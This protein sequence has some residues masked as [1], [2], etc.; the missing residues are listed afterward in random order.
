MEK[1][2]MEEHKSKKLN[3][4]V[5]DVSVVLS[6]IVA[7]F[8]VFSIAT[9]GIVSNQNGS[10]SY[11]APTGDSFT[12]VL[13]TYT[14]GDGDEFDVNV[15][16]T[17]G[18]YFYNFPMYYADSIALENQ[19][20]CV[21]RGLN[22]VGD[23]TYTKTGDKI[24]DPGLIYLLSLSSENGGNVTSYDD[25]ID[26]WVIQSA[27]WLYL[28]EKE[29]SNASYAFRKVEDEFNHIDDYKVLTTEGNIDIKVGNGSYTSYNVTG[30][31]RELV[32]AAKTATLPRVSV[33]K[34]SE[35][36]S[37]TT[38][39]QYYQTALITVAGSP[40]SSFTGYDISLTGIDGAIA[41]DENG[42]ELA[43]LT[44]VAPG[45]KFYVRVPVNKVTENVQTENVEIKGHFSA[46]SGYYYASSE[47]PQKM[48]T[49]APGD[50]LGGTSFELVYIPNTGMNTAQTIYF[51]GLIV[52]LCGIGIVYANAKPVESKQ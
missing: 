50:V 36:I 43:S 9:F 47:S 13:P 49:L 45:T 33:T 5:V 19:I 41:V 51:I 46:A 12:L 2:Y 28:Y 40:S 21:E 30:K 22:V 31:V 15:Q 20:F 35:D 26:G 14:D 48:V 44:N 18:T 29:P 8:A 23:S 11:A 16:A 10:V 4:S 34:A 52:L 37:K 24:T 38:D 7:I 3:Y 32:N 17:D 6:F 39:E 42:R 25:T 1:I 27:I